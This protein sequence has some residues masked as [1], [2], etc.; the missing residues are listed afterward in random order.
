MEDEG[1]NK[2]TTKVNPVADD[3]ADIS[4]ATDGNA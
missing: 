3:R 4:R 1:A 2:E